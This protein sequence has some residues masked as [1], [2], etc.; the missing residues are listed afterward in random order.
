MFLL[1]ESK[2][3]NPE[4]RHRENVKFHITQG[5]DQT[6]DPG[7]LK[8]QRSCCTNARNPV[9]QANIVPKNGT[10]YQISAFLHPVLLQ[11]GI[12]IS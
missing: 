4:E 10:R 7:V 6:E 1:S 3:E 11:V 5:Q 9:F 12:L 8:H 2:L